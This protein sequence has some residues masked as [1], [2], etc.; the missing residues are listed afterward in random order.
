VLYIATEPLL[1]L[2]LDSDRPRV[3]F[4]SADDAISSMAW[5][6]GTLHVNGVDFE[7]ALRCP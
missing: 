3:V 4:C 7:G 1:P 2:P 5:S 6:A